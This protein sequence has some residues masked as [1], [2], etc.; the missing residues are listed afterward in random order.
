MDAVDREEL[1]GLLAEALMRDAA[2]ARAAVGSLY[3]APASVPVS[4]TTR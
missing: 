4:Y 3:G 1:I 2:F